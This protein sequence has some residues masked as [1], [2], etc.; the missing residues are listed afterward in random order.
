MHPPVVNGAPL[1]LKYMHSAGIYTLGLIDLFVLDDMTELSSCHPTRLHMLRSAASQLLKR[2]SPD[3]QILLF[4]TMAS[5]S[6]SL[7]YTP[8]RAEELKENI[9]RVQ[10]EVEQAA[11]SG[12]RPSG[13][14][15][16]TIQISS[17]CITVSHSLILLLL[18]PRLVAV[19]K[20]KPASD[21]QALYDAGYRHFGENYIQEMVDKAE[22]LPKD[23]KWHFIGSLQS[24]KAKV[25]AGEYLPACCEHSGRPPAYNQ[26]T[27]R[28]YLQ[29]YRIYSSWKLYRHSKQP[30]Y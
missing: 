30:T 12:S 18:Q 17:I 28:W 8:D 19:S 26:N 14:A 6:T 5:T 20:L 25:A 10:K 1:P 21:I 22:A 4:R 13:L 16:V 3:S 15:A 7:E 24:N 2:R 27:I 11:A 9:E 23:I 29:L